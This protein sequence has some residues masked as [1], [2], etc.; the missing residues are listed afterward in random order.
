M[1]RTFSRSG[2]S[3]YPTKPFDPG[4]GSLDQRMLGL[5]RGDRVASVTSGTWTSCSLRSAVNAIIFGEPLNGILKLTRGGDGARGD[6]PL[7]QLIPRLR[8]PLPG[9]ALGFGYLVG[10]HLFSEY[11]SSFG[12]FLKVFALRPRRR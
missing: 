11:F 8:L 5:C 2:A 12:E 6:E 3:P 7:L 1:S 10:S 4:A 9:E